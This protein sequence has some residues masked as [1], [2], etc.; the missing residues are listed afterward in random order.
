[1]CSR[2]F[3]C[4]GKNL[5]QIGAAAGRN[6]HHNKNGARKVRRQT[7]HELLKR[8]YTTCGSADDNNV[9]R[10]HSGFLPVC[11]FL[12]RDV[13]RYRG[14]LAGLRMNAQIAS[15]N[16]SPFF[17]TDQPKSGTVSFA[18]EAFARVGNK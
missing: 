13:N 4:S 8:L 3:P 5:G 18:I 15:N 16:A 1:M 14:A 10:W 12:R 2:D 6:M 9:T 7:T 17:N 11:E